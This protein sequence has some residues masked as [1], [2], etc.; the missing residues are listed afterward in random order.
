M[1]NSY[2][3][4]GMYTQYLNGL[5]YSED[6]GGSMFRFDEVHDTYVRKFKHHLIRSS[7]SDNHGHEL[8]YLS[9]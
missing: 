2:T 1:G 7:S 6:V 4:H 9:G 5:I 8:S 3:D